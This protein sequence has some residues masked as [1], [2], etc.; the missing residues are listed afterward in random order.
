MN[1]KEMMYSAHK[2]SMIRI[3]TF[4]EIQSG[5]NPLSKEEIKKLAEKNPRI[6]AQFVKE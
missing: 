4:N 5:P 3:H 2:Q 6:W 1:Q